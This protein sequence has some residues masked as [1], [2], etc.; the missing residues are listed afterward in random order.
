MHPNGTATTDPTAEPADPPRSG[1]RRAWQPSAHLMAVLA[2]FKYIHEED[3]RDTWIEYQG[4]YIAV[5][6]KQLRGHG[7]NP[8]EMAERIAAELGV[9]PNRVAISYIHHPDDVCG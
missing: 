2:D 9:H 5:V 6:E 1:G 7:M 4:Q 8:T 3:D